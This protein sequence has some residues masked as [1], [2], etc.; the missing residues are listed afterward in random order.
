[1]E[2][3]TDNDIKVVADNSKLPNSRWY[4]GGGI[5]RPVS[6]IVGEKIHIAWEG[7]KVSTISY[8]PAVIQVETK[9]E[10]CLEDAF[11]ETTE[12]AVEILD[13]D[14]VIAAARGNQV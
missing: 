9:V 5:Y 2:F 7:V 6:L 14:K 1:M 8:E 10:S 3:G 13:G 12:I 11:M 4:S